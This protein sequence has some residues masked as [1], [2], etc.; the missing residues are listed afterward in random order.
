MSG[1]T[2]IGKYAADDVLDVRGQECPVPATET[3]K[4][5]DRM[6]PGQVLEIIATD[7]LAAVDLQIL[8]D[9]CGH[10][11]LASQESAA[12]LTVWIRVSPGR[13]PGAG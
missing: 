3:R 7:P 13:P 8:C 2:E 1:N 11:L 9:R 12:V 4:R 10:A 6:A 5:L